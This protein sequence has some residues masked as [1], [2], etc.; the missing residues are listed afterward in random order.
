M[1]VLV[2]L[3]LVACHK[4]FRIKQTGFCQN[5]LKASSSHQAN[6]MYIYCIGQR[7]HIIIII[8]VFSDG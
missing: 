2:L 6:F 3:T 8:I 1:I 5:L 4:K 7:Y